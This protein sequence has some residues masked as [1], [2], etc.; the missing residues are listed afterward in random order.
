M[1]SN[2]VVL[3]QTIHG[4]NMESEIVVTKVKAVIQLDIEEL[5]N[6]K[7]FMEAALQ[8]SSYLSNIVDEEVIEFADDFDKFLNSTIKGIGA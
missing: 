3:S 5:A 2:R 4:G 8:T 7:K 6:L 1:C